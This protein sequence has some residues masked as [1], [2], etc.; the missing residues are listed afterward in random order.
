MADDAEVPDLS[1]VPS[2][3]RDEEDVQPQEARRSKA[4]TDRDAD[5]SPSARH[6]EREEDGRGYDDLSRVLSQRVSN[7]FYGPVAASDATFGFGPAATP[8]LAPGFV[9]PE[10]VDGALR[11]FLPP[12]PCFDEALA[13][14]GA[15]HIVVL[16]GPESSGRGAGSFALL[17]EVLGQD[18]GLR[19]LSPANSLAELAT[20][21]ATKSHQAYVILDYVGEMNVD[22][23]QTF[24]I[25]KLSEELRRSNSYLVITAA[26]GIRR[27]LA[28]KDY[29][30]QWHAPDPLELLD[31]CR[32]TVPLVDLSPDVAAELERRIAVLR[33]PAEIVDAVTQLRVGPEAVLERL[34]DNER[35]TVRNWF[36]QEPP[37]GDLLPLAA[38]AFLEGIPERVFEMQSFQLSV[39]VRDW[40]QI[41]APREAEPEGAG[42]VP[43]RGVTFTQTRV[44]WKEQATS[45]IT[46]EWRPG[47]GQDPSRSERRILFGSP[48]I[49]ALVIAELHDL[50]GY[51]LWYP[52]RQWLTH[53]SEFGDLDVR[54]E[55]AKG[56]ALY[57]RHALAEVDEYLLQVWSDGVAAQRVT[58]ALTLQLMSEDEHLAPQA[59]NLALS[60]ADR[61]GAGRAV[62]T[63]MALTGT[64]GALYRLE[65]L[66]WLWFLAHR[67]ERVASAARRSMVLLLQTAEQDPER[68]LFTLRYVR[69][70]I[71]ATAPRSRKRAVA[72][73]TTTQLLQAEKLEGVGTLAAELLR[74]VPGSARHLGSLWVNVLLSVFRRG[75]VVA[76]CRT[77]TALRND[78]SVAGTVATL[79]EAMRDGMTARQWNKLSNDVS[80]ALKHPDYAIPG[81]RQL[82]VVLLGSLG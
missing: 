41:E 38:L 63:A 58:A 2:A 15:A 65:A 74:L 59:L 78:P 12:Q 44:K 69:T 23:V 66:N 24:E 20:Q 72:L 45:L 31:H 56:I 29:C 11:F 25:R 30:V 22:A 52:L 4:A 18:I 34:R 49:R 46:T 36:E 76:L 55:V 27:R 43:L 33:R 51:E 28:L 7:N 70:Q 5:W 6:D 53:L 8:G 40:E 32:R 1:E 39:Q 17:R 73:R 68:A 77:L 13:K 75:A 21:G 79:G 19:S 47:P 48:R 62:T 26:E 64:L 57:A 10:E 61:S 42:A 9:A 71:A 37:A 14:L 35:E 67:Q 50:Y 54:T 80:N 82:A 81:A 16:A 60:W 3:D